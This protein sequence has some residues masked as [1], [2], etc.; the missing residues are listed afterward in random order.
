VHAVQPNVMI[1]RA[2]AFIHR[3]R[4]ARFDTHTDATTVNLPSWPLL[5][6]C[7]AAATSAAAVVGA[8]IGG[9]DVA[10][11][12][13]LPRSRSRSQALAATLLGGVLLL[14]LLYGLL[15]ELVARSTLG[16]GALAGLVHAGGAFVA[17]GPRG[18]L[19]P[20]VSAAVVSLVYGCFIALLYVTP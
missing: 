8:F 10:A 11:W 5:F 2:T 6:W 9:R 12:S 19:R 13:L 1:R 3:D 18:E 20:A 16:T 4:C 14:P 17:A 7:G 15:F